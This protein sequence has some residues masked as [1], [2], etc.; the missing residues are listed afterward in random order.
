M[1]GT[2]GFNDFFGGI[3]AAQE[4]MPENG[5]AARLS[6]DDGVSPQAG[7]VYTVSRSFR[8]GDG[9]WVECFWEVLTVNGGNVFVRIHTPFEKIERFWEIADRA[10]YPADDAWALKGGAQ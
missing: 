4:R 2:M 8:N 9:S 5:I 6:A 3:R 1:S 7:H 10:W